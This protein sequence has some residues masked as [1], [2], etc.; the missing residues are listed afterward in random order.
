MSPSNNA[1][2]FSRV[3][4]LVGASP[5]AIAATKTIATPVP[6]T[7]EAVTTITGEQTRIVFMNAQSVRNKTMFINEYVHDDVIDILAITET[8]LKRSGDSVITTDLVLTATVSSMCQGSVAK[9]VVSVYFIVNIF[10]Q[11]TRIAIF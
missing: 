11:T 3:T 1:G 2:A 5:S 6:P 7:V 9:A 4:V 8:W 10:V